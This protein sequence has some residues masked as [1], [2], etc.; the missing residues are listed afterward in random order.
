MLYTLIAII[1]VF[2]ADID[3]VKT[4]DD[5]AAKM[6]FAKDFL[7]HNRR[8]LNRSKTK[9]HDIV[10]ILVLEH[11][12]ETEVCFLPRDSSQ[13]L[14]IT[15]ADTLGS[16]RIPHS[17]FELDDILFYWLDR[18]AVLTQETIDM[19]LRHQ[20]LEFVDGPPDWF[21]FDNQ[22]IDDGAY[23]PCYYYRDNDYRHFR[24]KASWG[25]RP[26]WGKFKKYP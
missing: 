1:S 12:D 9:R 21:L 10:K 4:S 13:R 19:F 11:G 17:Y 8:A 6:Y 3:S 24:K 25:L 14:L 18:K 26:F 23:V 5:M 16:N 15:D 2:T 20:F 7:K 22:G